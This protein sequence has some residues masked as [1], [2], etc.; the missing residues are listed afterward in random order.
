LVSAGRIG[1]SRG[2]TSASKKPPKR[3]LTKI[4][5]YGLISY[6]SQQNSYQRRLGSPADAGA[7][8]GGTGH[9][10]R[11]ALGP[12]YASHFVLYVPSISLRQPGACPQK[13][14]QTPFSEPLQ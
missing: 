1:H 13:P 10:P 14:R 5:T 6:V 9:S 8:A 4:S 3:R 11:A 7:G 2:K 12:S